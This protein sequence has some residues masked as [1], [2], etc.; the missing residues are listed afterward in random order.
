MKKSN[1]KFVFT[2]A[3]YIFLWILFGLLCFK[4]FL[5][6][7]INFCDYGSFIYDSGIWDIA[8][9]IGVLLIALAFQKTDES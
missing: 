9:A 2:N 4:I 3:L 1:R 6:A 8:E 5:F 7:T